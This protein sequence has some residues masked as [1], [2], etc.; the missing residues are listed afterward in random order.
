MT[1]FSKED[2]AAWEDSEIMKELEKIINKKE[3]E[4]W[5]EENEEN[6][7][8]LPEETSKE[9]EETLKDEETQEKDDLKDIE[10]QLIY[11]LQKIATNFISKSKNKNSYIVEE[12]IKNINLKIKEVK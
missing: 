2:T 12:C 1:K 6:H 7:E 4:S 10:S 8:E 5:E 3:E 9:S 11:N